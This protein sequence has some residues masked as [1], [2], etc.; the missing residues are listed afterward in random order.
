MSKYL[1]GGSLSESSVGGFQKMFKQVPLAAYPHLLVDLVAR[2]D[3]VACFC[4]NTL[5][6][7]AISTL[8]LA[9]CFLSALFSL[10][11][12]QWFSRDI[13]ALKRCSKWLS[14][15]GKFSSVSV[16]VVEAETLEK[17]VPSTLHSR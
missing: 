2:F 9:L 4:S 11:F 5:E 8:I 14:M 13:L 7:D 12:S 3:R 1:D 16:S 17:R 10:F 15:V 6:Y